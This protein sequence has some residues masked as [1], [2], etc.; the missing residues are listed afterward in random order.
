MAGVTST[1]RSIDSLRNLPWC[2]GL[3]AA[4]G[5]LSLDIG[6][7]TWQIIASGTAWALLIAGVHGVRAA[8]ADAKMTKLAGW[9]L[10][11]AWIGAIGKA[12]SYLP[13]WADVPSV[14]MA[15][16]ATTALTVAVG[17]G[18]LIL[19]VGTLCAETTLKDLARQWRYA[20]WVWLVLNAGW[21]GFL[22]AAAWGRVL[23]PNAVAGG[24]IA[25]RIVASLVCIVAPIVLGSSAAVLARA[26]RLSG[27]R[28]PQC[29]YSRRGL[30]EDRCPEC[31]AVSGLG[32]MSGGTAAATNL[33]RSALRWGWL[34]IAPGIAGMLLTGAA[35]WMSPGGLSWTGRPTWMLILDGQMT[36]R[37][38]S[39]GGFKL[40]ITKLQSIG[41]AQRA[42]VFTR[43]A[44]LAQRQLITRFAAKRITTKQAGEIAKAALAVQADATVPIG[45]WGSLFEDAYRAGVVSRDDLDRFLVGALK[46]KLRARPIV[47]Q[48]DPI[49]FEIAW[50]WRGPPL[51]AT[52][53]L[54]TS[55]KMM[56]AIQV[57]LTK[58]ALDGA[59]AGTVPASGT[60]I[61]Y[62]G[63]PTDCTYS[64]SG[65]RPLEGWELPRASA[66][67]GDRPFEVEATISLRP[68]Y[69]I[70]TLPEGKVGYE[71]SRTIQL[72]NRMKVVEPTA[73]VTRTVTLPAARKAIKDSYGAV[74][75]RT[76]RPSAIM[77]SWGSGAV[78]DPCE[79]MGFEVIIVVD[80]REYEA[81]SIAMGGNWPGSYMVT[82]EEAANEAL[83]SDMAEQARLLLRPSDAAAR[84]TLR[85]M[86]VLEGGDIDLGPVE[87]GG[88]R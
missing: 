49:P 2:F 73:V 63:G 30:R 44:D 57:D 34:L 59:P 42:R 56:A 82:I 55:D 35:L 76:H 9:V 5:P 66:E 6:S 88:K 48:G 40:A 8:R 78:P 26:I 28:C 36:E 45:G 58:I 3:I 38:D 19:R 52:G 43:E 81:G 18:V 64:F 24:W 13:A 7:K 60:L 77:L 17:V 69:N 27:D 79:E 86:R 74:W 21:Y 51:T 33:Q 41:D 1:T 31:G 62:S 70:P 84:R 16:F 85:G 54:P 25:P 32:V 67:P 83:K 4:W 71:T 75:W 68:G 53:V 14:A 15:I 22:T 80:G 61:P 72:M 50:E 46:F 11:L 87:R 47:A 23:D 12:V 39:L 65:T 10:M 20:G 29:G 37:I